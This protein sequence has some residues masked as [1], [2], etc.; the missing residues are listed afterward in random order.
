VQHIQRRLTTSFIEA[1]LDGALVLLTLAMMAAL[2][3]ALTA[4]ALA[5]VAV[6]GLLRWAFMR[7]LR[8]ATEE[9]LVHEARQA[10]HFLESLRGVQ[11]IKLFNAQADRQARFAAWWSTR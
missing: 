6:Y 8:E 7:P 9:A 11:A 3:P 5:A 4:V 2:Q 10:S 1:V